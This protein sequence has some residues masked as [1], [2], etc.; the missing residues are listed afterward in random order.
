MFEFRFETTLSQMKWVA[1]REENNS[2]TEGA[3]STFCLELMSVGDEG[4]TGCETGIS[5]PKITSSASNGN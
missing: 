2:S 5:T 3:W 4:S 1:S